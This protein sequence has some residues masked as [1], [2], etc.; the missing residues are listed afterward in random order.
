MYIHIYIYIYIFIYIYIYIPVVGPEEAVI[1]DVAGAT[2]TPDE[3]NIASN[4][5]LATLDTPETTVMMMMMMFT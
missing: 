4:E 1:V 3:A 2:T 5:I